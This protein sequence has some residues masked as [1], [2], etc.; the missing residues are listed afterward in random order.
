MAAERILIVEDDETLRNVMQLQLKKLGYE[1]AASPNAEQAVEILQKLQQDLIITDLN[2]PGKSGIELLKRVRSE[3]PGTAVIVMTAYGTIQ[4]AVAAMKC[5]AYDYLTKPIEPYD[6][7]ALVSRVMDHQR[8][9]KEVHVLRSC[10]DQKYGFE[11]IIGGSAPLLHALE[12]AARVAPTDA[13]VLILGET[14][15]GKE[16]VAKAIH[17]QS[18]RRDRPFVTINCAAIPRDL[19][20][21]ELFGYVK[22]AFTGALTHKKGK[23]EIA[24]GGTMLLDEIGEMPLELQVRVLRLIQE[25]E[26]EKIGAR[27]PTKVDVRIIAA[28]HR[29]LELMVKEGSF[30]EDLYYRLLVVPIVLPPLRERQPDIPDLVWHFLEKAKSKHNRADVSLPS[31]L[32]PTFCDYSWP[33]NVRQLENTIERLVLLT[34]SPEIMHSDLPDF[35]RGER[36]S[37]AVPQVDLP[38]EGIS[39]TAVEKDL[40]VRA[41]QK[42]GGNQTRAARFLNMS[43]RTLAYRLAK[44]DIQTEGLKIHKQGAG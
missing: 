7:R 1:A 3:Y 30:R 24:D 19:L 37:S 34:Q 10:L 14:G 36:P 40:I 38:E 2:L 42:F 39:L 11:N 32:L 33:G 5:G 16:M 4:S 44:Y 17:F 27:I 15:T 21:S 23:A 26:I 9:I 22:G 25:R 41:L 43:R 12:V 31:D 35:L 28:T 13:T 6:L 20:E 18:A 8:L 29:N